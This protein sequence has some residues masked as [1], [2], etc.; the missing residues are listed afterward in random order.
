MMTKHKINLQGTVY[1]MGFYILYI[2]FPSVLMG[3]L[4]SPLCIA[5]KMLPTL[6]LCV[7]KHSRLNVCVSANGC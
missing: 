2:T 5:S 7:R 3:K 6:P 1:D 4:P